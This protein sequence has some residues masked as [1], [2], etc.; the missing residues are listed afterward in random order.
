LT[1]RFL[2]RKMKEYEDLKDE[3]KILKSEVEMVKGNTS[4]N[5]AE[6]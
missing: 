3:I 6:K 1:Y 4:C 2:E 5:D